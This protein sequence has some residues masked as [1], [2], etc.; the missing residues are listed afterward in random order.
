[1]KIDKQL[2]NYIRALAAQRYPHEL[3]GFIVNGK[4]I[5][6][7]NISDEPDKHFAV[8]KG[9]F[10]QFAPNCTAF[11]H[12]HPDWYPVPSQKDMEQQMAT[13]IPWGILS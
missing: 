3:C 11:I 9:V 7:N 1:M 2:E 12:S 6:V 5:E 8:E 13:T 4:F 10:Q